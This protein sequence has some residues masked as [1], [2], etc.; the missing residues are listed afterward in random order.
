MFEPIRRLIAELSDGGKHPTHFDENDC[1]VAAAALLVHSATIDGGVSEAERVKL[2]AVIKQRFNLDDD[3]TDELIAKATEAERQAIDLY[4][5]TSRLNRAL[6]EQGRARLIEMMWQVVFA[7]GT[8]TEFEDNL[9]WRAADLL[10][11]SRDER[12]AL[13]ERVAGASAGG[14]GVTQ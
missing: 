6:D 5:F 3:A 11:I 9:M 8:V 1:R 2:H 4:R 12:I 10:G 14:N 13:R 7:D